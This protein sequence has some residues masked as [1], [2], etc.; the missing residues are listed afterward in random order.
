[1]IVRLSLADWAVIVLYFSAV[2]FVG[3][4]AA[5]KARTHIDEY[6]VAGRSLTLP[7]FVATLVSTWYGGILGV[8][9][10]SYRYGISNWFIFGVPYYFFAILFAIFLA[11]RVH[12][13]RL[14]TIPDKLRE[15]Y[16]NAT[17]TMGSFLTLFIVTPAPYVLMVGII[18]EMISGWSLLVS[19][20]FT[21]VASIAYLYSGGL[22]SDVRTNSL[23]FV[24][25]YIGFGVILPYCYLH[26]GGLSFIKSHVPGGHLT[27]TG[28]NSWQYIIA[29][30]F[31]ASWTLID[32]A[33]HQRCYAAKSGS[34]AR[35][36]I[37][38]SVI[39]W[40]FFDFMTSTTG[41]YARAIVPT[42]EQP[43]MS[44]PALAEIVLPSFIKGLF[45]VGL[46][47]TIMSS[48][49]SLTFISAVTIGKDILFRLFG[50]HDEISGASKR[51]LANSQIGIFVTAIISI[52]ISLLVP[53][54][55]QIWYD[56][57]T[58]FIP[59]LLIPLVSSY[60]PRFHVHRKYIFLSMTFGWLTSLLWLV[61]GFIMNT[62]MNPKYLLNIQPM[63][64]GL[65]LSAIFYLS[66]FFEKEI[67]SVEELKSSGDY[68]S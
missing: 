9:E 23:E 44:Y 53:S 2:V 21:T 3:F 22:H 38:V 43:A 65:I 19:V 67:K 59:G 47:A 50:K 13:A 34:V 24:L 17:A 18:V 35:Y 6:L 1:M 30:F 45:Y 37:L 36:G 57:G 62:P 54:V 33:F 68:Q 48:L 28:G 51:I 10:F 46:L 26:Y 55:I 16:G 64:P 42:L 52:A 58:V 40:L 14:H 39:F 4:R 31:I 27:L 12:G 7:V 49:E 61:S 25:M 66:G 32:P 60:F 15:T 5:R 56:L 11:P 29:W 41:L 63:Y 8:G 20:L